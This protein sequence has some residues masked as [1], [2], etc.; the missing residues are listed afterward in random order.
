MTYCGVTRSATVNLEVLSLSSWTS[1]PASGRPGETL[2]ATAL[3][4][5]APSIPHTVSMASGDTTLATIDSF[6]STVS[7]SSK[8][9]VIRLR[10]SL[11]ISRQVPITATPKADG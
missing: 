5:P 1:T 7:G 9:V 4:S 8:V 2:Q 11:A 10:G 3:L 6:S